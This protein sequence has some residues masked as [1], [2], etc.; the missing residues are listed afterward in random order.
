M[1]TRVSA[2]WVVWEDGEMVV[3]LGEIHAYLYEI[4][5]SGLLHTQPL[6]LGAHHF[7]SVS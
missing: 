5:T 3:L 1:L 2:T 7:F 6:A 4:L